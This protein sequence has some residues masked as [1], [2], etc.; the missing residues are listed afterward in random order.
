MILEMTAGVALMYGVGASRGV[1]PSA[2]FVAE[3]SGST[4]RDFRSA[5]SFSPFHKTALD[6]LFDVSEEC[7]K[8]GWDGF[9]ALPVS[10]ETYL[11]AYRLLESLPA[12]IPSPSIGAEPDGHVTMEWYL[13]PRRTLSIS[14]SP[15][16][17]IHYAALNGASKAYGSEP[18]TGQLPNRLLDLVKQ[19][20]G[21]SHDA[22]IATR[23]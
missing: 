15:E 20:T 10:H 11:S 18:A 19:V 1:S 16:G 17:E 22:F 8:F 5:V 6:Q 7:S 14:L 12:N 9:G 21:A 13:S 3:R 23:C 4:R 2:Q